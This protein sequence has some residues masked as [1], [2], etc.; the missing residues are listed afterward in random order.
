LNGRDTPPR[1]KGQVN[2]AATPPVHRYPPPD[3]L[4]DLVRH[5]WVPEW[6]LP[7]G[8]RVTARVLG[9]PS[10][11]VVVEERAAIVSGPTTKVSERVLEGHGWAVGALLHPAATPLLGYDATA[12]RDRVEVLTEPGLVAAVSTAMA[13]GHEAACA[14]LAGWL[15]SRLGRP[16][17]HGLLANRAV[18][19]AE[20]DVAL[21]RVGEL[22][23]RLHVSPRTLERAVRRCTGF[24]PGEVLRRRRL[25]EAADRLAREDAGGGAAPATLATLASETGFADHAHMSREFRATLEEAPSRLRRR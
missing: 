12:L 6:H 20:D 13:E 18:A 19:L 21:D 2:P 14:A 22:A 3:D 23:A 10:L 16:T 11:N 24:T 4:V 5:W 7:P 17:V 9:Y 8:V 25:Q 15:R 1:S